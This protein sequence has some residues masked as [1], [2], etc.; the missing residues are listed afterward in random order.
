M[1][2]Y[3]KSVLTDEASG[4]GQYFNKKTVLRFMD[5]H[6][7]GKKDHGFRLWAL[8]VFGVWYEQT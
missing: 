5:E 1:S 4:L 7:S 8:L 2:Y 6:I 3:L